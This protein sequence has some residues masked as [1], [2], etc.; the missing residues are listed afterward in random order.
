MN[1]SECGETMQWRCTNQET[2]VA[3][4]KCPI[5]GNEE[6]YGIPNPV[7]GGNKN[8]YTVILTG[9]FSGATA[10]RYVCTK[11]GYLVEKFEGEELRKIASRYGK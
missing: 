4:Y 10:N 1:C 6:F 3:K 5:C 7:S 9:A 11:C 8:V 2:G